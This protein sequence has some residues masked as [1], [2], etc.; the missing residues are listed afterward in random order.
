MKPGNSIS[1]LRARN[2]NLDDLRA[3]AIIGVVSVHVNSHFERLVPGFLHSILSLGRFGVQLFFII[4]GYLMASM[5]SNLQSGRG[6][7]T[8][9]IIRLYPLW[10]LFT[11]HYLIVNGPHNFVSLFL[12]VTM[13][14]VLLPLTY[15]DFSPGGWTISAEVF[16]YLLWPLF[17]R[18]SNRFL[19]I[20]CG[21]L[22]IVSGLCGLYV[23]KL[24]LTSS[25]AQWVNTSAVWNTTPFFISGVLIC[26]LGYK[27]KNSKVIL[28]ILVLAWAL[29]QLF[30]GQFIPFA[31]LGI[32]SV[33]ILGVDKKIIFPRQLTKIGENTY[34]IYF[35]HWFVIGIFSR[36]FNLIK[37][38]KSSMYFIY[39]L[40]IIGLVT[41]LSLGISICLTHTYDNPARK[42]LNNKLHPK[43]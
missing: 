7:L 10:I 14:S 38:K 22:T 23:W 36:F 30:V 34:Q 26:R 15:R 3:L 21:I 18:R 40:V 31:I 17:F 28:R 32:S 39:E 25:N 9:R 13:M 42:F 43:P 20:L 12:G 5:Y 4:S 33:F 1:N 6:F 8:K 37:F 2:S 27:F 19:I 11:L 24:G 41:I 35:I 29:S 16:N